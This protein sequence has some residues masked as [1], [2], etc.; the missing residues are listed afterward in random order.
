MPTGDAFTASIGGTGPAAL[1]QFSYDNRDSFRSEEGAEIGL[2]T[3]ER[4]LPRIS[5]GDP[6]CD[7]EPRRVDV[8]Y[9]SDNAAASSFRLLPP[10][11]EC[12]PTVG[13]GRG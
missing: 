2:D 6:E 9:V 1:R 12:R 10:E 11:R 7:D 4:L 3:F 13:F 5:T 8:D